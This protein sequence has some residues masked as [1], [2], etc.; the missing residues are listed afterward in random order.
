MVRVTQ[1]AGGPTG[2]ADGRA[3]AGAD[4]PQR[5]REARERSGLSLRE[6]ARRLDLSAS[7][8]SQIETGKSRPSVRTLYA[9]VSELG[10]SLDELFAAPAQAPA[11]APAGLE[12]ALAA[13]APASPSSSPAIASL[14]RAGR[15]E[16]PTVTVDERPELQLASGVTWARLTREHDQ[17]VDFLQVRYEPG[18]TSNADGALVRHAGHEYGVV[19]SGRLEV[20]VGF[21]TYV[22]EEG[23]SISFS[24]TEP[25]LLANRSDEPVEAIW[26]VI[27]RR[28]TDPRDPAFD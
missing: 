18:A 13:M 7:A 8:L 19:L 24:S 5:L 16:A 20:S 15:S 26:F 23:G 27:G 9:V 1:V 14:T 11:P 22:L 12:E 21:E 10:L 28:G 2:P 6:L 25:H 17:L 4:V 3:D